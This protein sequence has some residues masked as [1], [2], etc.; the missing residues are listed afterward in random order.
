[1]NLAP[2]ANSNFRRL[3][4]YIAVHRSAKEIDRRRAGPQDQ[5][6]GAD[7]HES[8]AAVCGLVAAWRSAIVLSERLV[9]RRR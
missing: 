9:A 3:Y 4:S 5:H 8:A 6:A 2:L 7:R 1:M